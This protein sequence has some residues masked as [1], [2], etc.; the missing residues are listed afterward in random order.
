MKIYEAIKKDHD[1]QRD[2]CNRLK[3]TSGDSKE[4]KKLWIA[5]KKE[6]EVHALAEE[7][8]FYS[9]LIDS[10]EMQ[11]D[12]RHGM[13]EHHEMDELIEELTNTDMSSPH[14][15][16]TL[17]KLADK[18][19]HHLEDEEEDF[20]VKAKDLYS[21]KEADSLATSYEATMEKYRKTW[22][23]SIPGKEE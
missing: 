12:A 20:F 1:V 6:L 9:P 14:W 22:P 15:L 18:V 2:L 19:E 7:R 13:A 10:D 21:E 5:L 23:E 4:R 11:E 17:K 3:D 16:A 8:Y